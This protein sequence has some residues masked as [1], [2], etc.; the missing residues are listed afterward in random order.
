MERTSP[1]GHE[2]A[3]AEPSQHAELMI[4]L[5]PAPQWGTAR[6]LVPADQAHHLVTT[7]GILG[8]LV[9]G[10][11]GAVL[12]LHTTVAALAYA[13]LALALVAAVLIAACSRMGPR[14]KGKRQKVSQARRRP[15]GKQ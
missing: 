5:G 3:L 9:T 4:S 2:A 1:P 8:S 13:E 6:G 7:F 10:I 15:P 11:G 14:G 12:T